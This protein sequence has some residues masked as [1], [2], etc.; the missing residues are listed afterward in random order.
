MM[1]LPVWLLCQGLVTWILIRLGVPMESIHDI[2]GS[3]V[4]GWHWEWETLGRFLALSGSISLQIIGGILVASLI[5]ARTGFNLFTAWLFWSLLLAWPL[6]WVIVSEAATDNVTE[7]V[8]NN[9]SFLSSGLLILG[10]L[11]VA[12][13]GSILSKTIASRTKLLSGALFSFFAIIFATS[14]FWFGAE[15]FIVKYGKIFSAW[16]FLLSTNRQ[17][18][19]VG[20]ELCVRYSAALFMFLCV[21]ALVQFSSWKTVRLTK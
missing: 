21:F 14:C 7:L 9:A 11:A 12:S 6:Y 10:I 4:L 3:P 17:S 20:A 5:R 16:Q 18:Y 15:H 1:L 2:V 19:A 13:A 8:A